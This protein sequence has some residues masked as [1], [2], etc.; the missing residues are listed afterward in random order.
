[1]PWVSDA[2]AVLLNRKHELFRQYK[3]GTGT[4]DHYIFLK[5]SF[6]TTQRS[7]RNNYFR[8]KFTECSNNSGDTWITVYSLI[9][10]KN[11]SKDVILNSDSSVIAEVCNNYFSNVATNL[12]HNIS[13]SNISPLNFLGAPVENYFFCP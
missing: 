8:R 11:Q 13:H 2:I 1:M 12:D 6:T 9:R 7:A 3:N 10:C 5:N 4:F